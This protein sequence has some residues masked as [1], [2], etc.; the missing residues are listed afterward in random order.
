M[1][2]H[3][4]DGR[5]VLFWKDGHVAVA[6]WDRFLDNDGNWVYAWATP[7][8][9]RFSGAEYFAEVEKPSMKRGSRAKIWHDRLHLK[10][11]HWVRKRKLIAG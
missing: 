8:G 1:L 3:L 11:A 9:D 6:C 10:T 2:A 4:K 5:D 7:E